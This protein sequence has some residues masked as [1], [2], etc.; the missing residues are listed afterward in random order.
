[1]IDCVFKALLSFYFYGVLLMSCDTGCTNL[2]AKLS[3]LMSC[4]CKV[5]TDRLLHQ[6]LSFVNWVALACRELRPLE[7][8]LHFYLNSSKL[9]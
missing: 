2:A 1:M 6:R 8:S 4:I 7:M 3:S 9:V 5:P